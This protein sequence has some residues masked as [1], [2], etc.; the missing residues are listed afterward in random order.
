[1]D[2]AKGICSGTPVRRVRPALLVDVRRLFGG[3]R[4]AGIS[5][6]EHDRL[7]LIFRMGRSMMTVQSRFPPAATAALRKLTGAATARTS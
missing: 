1:M 2:L 6:A 7:G 5:G 3:S 4:W